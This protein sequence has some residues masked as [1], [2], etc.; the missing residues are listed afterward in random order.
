MGG[1]EETAVEAEE[2]AEEAAMKGKGSEAL[3]KTKD[4]GDDLLEQRSIRTYVTSKHHQQRRVLFFIM[5]L[6]GFRTGIPF[7]QLSAMLQQ[8]AQ[9]ETWQHALGDCGD[10][11][12]FLDVLYTSWSSIRGSLEQ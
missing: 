9:D 10:G 8:G 4:P 2:S 7:F 11:G 12:E 1:I 6:W 3:Q 5:E